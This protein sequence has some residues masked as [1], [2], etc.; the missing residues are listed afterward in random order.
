MVADS[1]DRGN[2]CRRSGL[3]ARGSSVGSAVVPRGLQERLSDVCG[4]V[5]GDAGGQM[6][7]TNRD[8]AFWRAF[9]IQMY[10]PNI[11]VNWVGCLKRKSALLSVRL[12]VPIESL[13]RRDSHIFPSEN[14]NYWLTP[15]LSR[16][17][18]RRLA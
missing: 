10:L 5:V 4:H 18:H 12:T 11:R 1:N 14:F 16:D 2:G 15:V 7:L 17:G 6:T 8:F 13:S 3:G 9:Q